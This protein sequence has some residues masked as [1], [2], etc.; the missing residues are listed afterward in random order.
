VL[1]RQERLSESLGLRAR[2]QQI[3]HEL[4]ALL[5]PDGDPAMIAETYLRQGDLHILLHR[6]DDG[7][8]AL[9]QSLQTWRE[10]ADPVGEQKALRSLGL[11]RWYE[12]RHQ[13]A[14][15]CIAQVVAMDR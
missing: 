12:G 8:A 11:L 2:Q 7:E 14:L 9:Q 6:F 13:E 4:L 10:L 5:E 3:I 15:T 1:L